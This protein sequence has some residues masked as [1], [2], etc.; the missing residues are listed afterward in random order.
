MHGSI[1]RIAVV[2]GT[3]KVGRKIV[4]AALE[5][6][7]EV[8]S[9]ARRMPV[10]NEA[11]PGLEAMAGDARDIAALGVL[12]E[13]C[14]A[15][16]MTIA[17]R[18]DEAPGFEAAARA[19]VAAIEAGGVARCVVL[20]GLGIDVPGDRK[21][22]GARLQGAMMNALFGSA[23]RDKQRGVEAVMESG[24]EWT[25][26]RAPLIEEGPP[27]GRIEANTRSAPRGSARAADL[28]E[29]ILDAALGGS[30]LREAP[31]VASRR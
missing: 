5:R 10:P 15:A 11:R 6:G 12:L 18:R 1:S 9:L 3:G 13:G 27:L 24:L 22:L 16:I 2:G 14:G 20:V 26:V 19:L 23:M 4:E 8:R 31:F 7:L 21:G 25:I 28:A 29:F 30:F 17:S